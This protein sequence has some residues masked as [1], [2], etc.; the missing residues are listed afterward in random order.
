MSYLYLHWSVLHH[1]YNATRVYYIITVSPLEYITSYEVQ[2]FIFPLPDIAVS[3]LLAQPLTKSQEWTKSNGQRL[4][5]LPQP[6]SHGLH[7]L[8]ERLCLLA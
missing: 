4:N 6:D 5:P 8:L 7:P 3:C 1:N 2:S